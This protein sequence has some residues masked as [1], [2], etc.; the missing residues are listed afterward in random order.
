MQKIE[1]LTHQENIRKLNIANGTVANNDMETYILPLPDLQNIH[2]NILQEYIKNRVHFERMQ[3]DFLLCV[4]AQGK[5][6]NRL[7]GV[8]CDGQMACAS[9]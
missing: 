7:V 2:G 4:N 8:W 9:A 5:S 3:R 6:A 1:L